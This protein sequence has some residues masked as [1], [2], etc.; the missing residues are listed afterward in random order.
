V[1]ARHSWDY[2]DCDIWQV[3]RFLQHTLEIAYIVAVAWLAAGVVDTLSALVN[4]RLPEDI[5]DNVGARRIRTR[6][7]LLRQFL[8]GLICFSAFAAVLM[9]FPKI[10]NG[11]KEIAVK[12][13][14]PA[15]AA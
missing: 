7:H 15:W 9:T 13:K 2:H 5:Q 14:K 1:R 8:V 12:R 6:V 3:S 11:G 10:P 4:R